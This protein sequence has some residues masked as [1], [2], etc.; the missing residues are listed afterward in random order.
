M[1]DRIGRK[2][3][4]VA[5]ACLC[6]VAGTGGLWLD[7]LIALMIS[8]T[9]LGAGVA[10]LTIC[11]MSLMGDLFVSGAR[12]RLIGIY[13]TVTAIGAIGAVY[14]AGLLAETSWRLPFGL[15]LFALPVIALA[16][17]VNLRSHGPAQQSL[18][19]P[20]EEGGEYL[21]WRVVALAYGLA[22]ADQ[23]AYFMLPSQLPF[24]LD[25]RGIENAATLT[26]T[27]LGWQIFCLAGAALLFGRLRDYCTRPTLF[28]LGFVICGAAYSLMMVGDVVALFLL[29]TLSGIGSA[30]ILPTLQSMIIG[31]ASE[32]YRGRVIGGLT[33]VIASGQFIS[34]L[35]MTPVIAGFGAAAA[36][37][38][39]GVAL[40]IIG[41]GF[42]A[43]AVATR[44][45][46]RQLSRR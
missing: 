34:P 20:P 43:F 38:A 29:A 6:G 39:A 19:G 37:L 23:L 5:A 40:L 32:Q 27:L 31:S 22:F 17:W 46:T 15:F 14:L 9:L 16:L 7:D 21:D 2:P 4:L 26:G 25:A 24:I 10:V 1:I 42:G 36:F 44:R 18:T 13:A 12:E 30:M 28:C 3:A 8:L 45:P 33:A 11:A 35:L 41:A